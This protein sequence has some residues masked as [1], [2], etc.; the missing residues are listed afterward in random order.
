MEAKRADMQKAVTDLIHEFGAV[1]LTPAAGAAAALSLSQGAALGLK[2]IR[3]SM[4]RDPNANRSF[5]SAEEEL[6]S[7]S[8]QGVLKFDEDCRAVQGLMAAP[9]VRGDDDEPRSRRKSLAIHGAMRVPSEIL[10]LSGEGLRILAGVVGNVRKSL[11]CEIGAGASLMWAAAQTSCWILHN[12]A[13]WLGTPKERSDA[14]KE[15]DR[16][17]ETSK[18]LYGAVSVAVN[19]ALA[20]RSDTR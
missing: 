18:R 9:G 4:K 7:I 10:G 6:L 11:I 12:N 16:A 15:A 13:A 14:L 8:R 19:A 1:A 3:I 20:K 5:A 2:A 17:M